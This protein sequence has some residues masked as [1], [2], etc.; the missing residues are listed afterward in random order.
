MRQE[1]PAATTCGR[2]LRQ[3][4]LARSARGVDVR[5]QV[6]G[7]RDKHGHDG[8]RYAKGHQSRA[9]GVNFVWFY[10]VLLGRKSPAG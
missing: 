4:R 5:G 1:R 9:Y 8:G 10:L 7:G 2:I 6:V 3:S